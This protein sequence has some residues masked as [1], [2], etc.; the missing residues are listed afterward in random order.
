M[1]IAHHLDAKRGSLMAILGGLETVLSSVSV[2]KLA[3]FGIALFGMAGEEL[4]ELGL[5]DV[6]ELGG[7]LAE[8]F[9]GQAAASPFSAHCKT[10]QRRIEQALADRA[11]SPRHR[12]PDVIRADLNQA[13][14]Q[15]N[16]TLPKMLVTPAD[17]V[18]VDLDTTR[19]SVQLRDRL[20]AMDA[21]FR[22]FGQGSDN[23]EAHDLAFELFRHACEAALSD[24]A[25]V[26]LIAMPQARAALQRLTRIESKIDTQDEK[27]EARHREM[28]AAIARE[29]GVELRFLT[30]LFAA[31][32]M[33]D[34]IPVG[35]EE[36]YIGAAVDALK[37]RGL[38]TITPSNLGSEIDAA[39]KQARAKLAEADAEGA[40]DILR[41]RRAIEADE[42]LHRQRGEALLLFEEAKIYRDTFRHD[43]AMAALAQATR[44]DPDKAIYW[45]TLGDI[46]M[47]HGGL[48]VALAAYQ[49]AM[50]ASQK[51]GDERDLSISHDRI[52][53]VLRA[54]GDLAGALDAFRKGLVIRETLSRRDAGNMEW[55]RDLSISHD[56]IGDVLS[57][58]GDL[59]GALDAFRK[60]L[61]IRETLSRRDADNMEW[62]RDLSISHNRIGDMRSEQGDLAGAL[63]AFRKGLAIRETLSSRDAGNM[64][65]QRD[66]S[67]SHDRIGDVLSA[68]GDLAGALDAFRKGLAIAEILSCRDA[69]NMQWQRDLSVSHDKIGDVLSAQDDLAGA[70][71]AYGKYLA[72]AETLSRR[73]AGNMQWQRDMIVSHVKLGSAGETPAAHFRAA[74]EI[75]ARMQAAGRLNPADAWMVDEAKRLWAEAAKAGK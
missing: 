2:T 11:R 35:Q 27:A 36:A 61:A 25:A 3:G 19:A 4:S 58:Q 43:E 13:I 68:Q 40:L 6:G 17:L 49:A 16:I 73:D 52:G 39:L 7:K 21:T 50:A 28:M 34:T 63:D 37:A 57:A 15:F 9:G 12:D 1:R 38:E 32:E 41:A 75:A 51:S 24:R 31:A 69:G 67:I 33:D 66:L 53:D 45:G 46:A 72:I 8:A 42:R 55:Q 47:T 44:L 64:E 10:V 23:H 48:D 60:G 14:A 29:K 26:A 22:P 20:A 30:P 56:R 70:L 59:A 54:Q 71:D 18:S 65:W 74:H 5:K 62:Q